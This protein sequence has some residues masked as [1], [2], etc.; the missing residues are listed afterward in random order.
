[1]RPP[2]P[3]GS[4]SGRV[5]PLARSS[6]A[7]KIESHPAANNLWAL[8]GRSGPRRATRK[9]HYS[10]CK[11]TPS[12]AGA[13]PAAG[14]LSLPR[15]QKGAAWKAFLN[16]VFP[17]RVGP[18]RSPDNAAGSTPLQ[19]PTPVRYLAATTVPAAAVLGSDLV[20]GQSVHL[21]RTVVRAR[22]LW[23]TCQNALGWWRHELAQ[24]AVAREPGL[25]SG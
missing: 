20:Y 7:S 17:A 21:P 23:P 4:P 8:L 3:S 24:I 12:A 9:K 13:W 1:M 22:R 19:T 25:C 5:Q 11:L 15:K 10:T 14:R 18:P 6:E 16:P 2:P